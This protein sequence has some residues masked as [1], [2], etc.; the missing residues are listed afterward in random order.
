MK[1][2]AA[3][4]LALTTA[5]YRLDRTNTRST[6]PNDPTRI[7][8][9]GS[10]RTN[11]YE[12][13]ANGSVTR[14]GASPAAMPIRTRTSRAPRPAPRAGAQVGQVPHHTLSLWNNYRVTPQLSAGLGL[15]YRS[16]MFVAV[17]N[18][19]TLPG[20]TRAD[21]ALFYTLTPAVRAAGSTSRTCS[22]RAITSTPTATRT[23][24]PARRAP[25][26]SG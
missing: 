6:D 8:Q 23:S 18:A 15:L 14:T 13:G 21:A 5:L 16:D 1:W 24:R 26:A 20:Y 7:I 2:D 10:Q 19:V 9:T 3:Q 4:S 12:F 25:F 17:D 22:T 11:G